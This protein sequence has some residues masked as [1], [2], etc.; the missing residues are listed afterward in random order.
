M[1]TNLLDDDNIESEYKSSFL[2]ELKKVQIWLNVSTAIGFMAGLGIFFIALIALEAAAIKTFILGV[3]L[4]VQM[5]LVFYWCVNVFNYTRA[6]KWC[7]PESLSNRIEHLLENNSRL[8]RATA[9][10][11]LWFLF[12]LAYA[13]LG[14]VIG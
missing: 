4:I 5:C 3:L 10:L 6:I 8:W 9:L 2:G 12:T 13:F 1:N 11:L 14:D 7:N